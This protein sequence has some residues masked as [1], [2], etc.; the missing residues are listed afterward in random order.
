MPLITA[1]V[2]SWLIAFGEYYFQVPANRIGYGE[3]TG[4]R[5]AGT[6]LCLS[7]AF[8]ARSGLLFGAGCNVGLP[9]LTLYAG[10]AL[11]CRA[12]PRQGRRK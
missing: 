10:W 8:W 6:T 9:N 2:T 3:F 12:Q 7:L 4:Y 11:I 1:I 5:C